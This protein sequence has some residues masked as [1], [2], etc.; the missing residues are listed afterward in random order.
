MAVCQIDIKLDRLCSLKVHDSSVD[1]AHLRWVHEPLKH[2]YECTRQS[3]QPVL[4]VLNNLTDN[5]AS[6]DNAFIIDSIDSV[7]DRVVECLRNCA[8][9]F[10]P[11]RIFL[12]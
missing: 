6:C 4:D 2:Y 5:S 11:K 8:N 12:K 1:V 3:L 9:M 7:Y 10:I